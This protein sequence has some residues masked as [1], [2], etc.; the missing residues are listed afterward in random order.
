[1]KAPSTEKITRIMKEMLQ[2]TLSGN[3]YPDDTQFTM[4]LTVGQFRQMK[5]WFGSKLLL[6]YLTA[7]FMA[8]MSRAA[9]LAGDFRL[10]T[11]LMFDSETEI[12]VAKNL[13]E[14][15]KEKWGEVDEARV[16]ELNE[17][18]CS[19][20]LQA[21]QALADLLKKFRAGELTQEDLEKSFDRHEA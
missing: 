10:S 2:E 20:E 13:Y 4:Q 11:K 18:V 15:Y 19:W 5:G 7:I 16:K 1:M 14:H 9:L 17:I 3:S 21:G 12:A 6:R 8:R